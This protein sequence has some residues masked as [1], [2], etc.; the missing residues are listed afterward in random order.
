MGEC[1]VLLDLDDTL[2]IQR[3]VLEE[4]ELSSAEGIVGDT[5]KV[6]GSSRTD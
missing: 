3:E 1:A 6:R 5:W 2:V 4:A